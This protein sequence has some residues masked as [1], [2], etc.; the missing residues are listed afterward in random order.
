[1]YNLVWGFILPGNECILRMI[2]VDDEYPVREMLRRTIPW[3]KHHVSVVGVAEDGREAVELVRAFKPELVLTDIRMLGMDGI[4]LSKWV[5]QN[6]P[7]TRV[8]FLSAYRDFENAKMAL[9]Y[10]VV[11]YILK[12]VD[13]EQLFTVID[14]VRGEYIK[15]MN[16]AE[17]KKRM[18][19]IIEHHIPR[20]YVKYVDDL[21]NVFRSM[22]T[23]NWEDTERFIRKYFENYRNDWKDTR[24]YLH[25]SA[26]EL[27]AVIKR[28]QEQNETFPR[29]NVP[30]QE[31]DELKKLKNVFDM[32]ETVIRIFREYFD[33]ML[34]S[35]RSK[36]EN[37]IGEIK[38]Y[39]KNHCTDIIKISDVASRFHISPSYLSRL[40]KNIHGATFIDFLVNCRL[41]KAKELLLGSDAKIYEV[42]SLAGFGSEKHFIRAFKKHFGLSPMKF[43]E[44]AIKKNK[45]RILKINNVSLSCQ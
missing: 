33:L 35:G 32:C 8:I 40:F 29:Y 24:E 4:D 36:N 38:E 25:V 37:L 15:K 2:I 3:D 20:L 11:D 21:D 7:D 26:F 13:E 44:E 41:E 6:C 14:K 23:F 19:N 16:E 5:Y 31:L 27:L 34:K 18:R 1:M 45:S 9:K 10:D 43:R 28:L 42:S 12:P 17:E 39:V 22:K 30:Q